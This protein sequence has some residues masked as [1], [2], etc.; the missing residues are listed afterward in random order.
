LLGKSKDVR[1]E[2]LEN[3]RRGLL[4]RDGQGGFEETQ[5]GSQT[6][7]PMNMPVETQKRVCT[8]NGR[9]WRQ[10]GCWEKRGTR[11]DCGGDL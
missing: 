1:R 11:G 3:V 5:E 9:W 4:W 10:R 6:A 7:V 8:S 2:F